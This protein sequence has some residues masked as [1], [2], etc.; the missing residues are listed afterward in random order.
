MKKISLLFLSLAFVAFVNAQQ[1]TK[2]LPIEKT[3]SAH[4][5][6]DYQNAFYSYWEPFN[7]NKGFYI[8]KNGVEKKASGW[9]QFK[10]WEYYW[11]T[12]VDSETGKFPVSDV[13]AIFKQEKR[14]AAFKSSGELWTSQGP[15]TSDGGYAGIGRV[16]VIAYHPT[17]ADMF[18]VGTASGGLWV[19]AD[20][21]QSWDVLNDDMQALG[22]SD[23]IIPSDFETS[24]TIY[25]ATGDRDGYDTRSIGLLKSTDAGANW[26]SMDLDYNTYNGAIINS[27]LLD[28]VGN[29]ILMVAGN[30]GLLKSYNSKFKSGQVLAWRQ[31]SSQVFIDMENKPGDFNTVYASTKQGGIYVSTDGGVNWDQPVS[32]ANGSRVELA[33]TPAEPT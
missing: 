17:N 6:F 31:I 28:P 2:N 21:G 30:F 25:L 1:W 20:G 11:E 19:T 24:Q 15:Q 23:I 16:N 32:E 8:D 4:T 7:V 3:S 14:A 18:W 22:V 33:V 12:R 27:V 13:N 10:R 9:K 29:S 5:F 26:E